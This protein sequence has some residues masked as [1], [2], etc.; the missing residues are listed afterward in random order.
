MNYDCFASD[1]SSSSS[2][3]WRQ[4]RPGIATLQSDFNSRRRPRRLLTE[5]PVQW[6][7]AVGTRIAHLMNLPSGWDGYGGRPLTRLNAYF[8]VKMLASVC[9]PK[10]ITPSLV[11]LPSGGVQIEWHHGTVDFEITIHSPSRIEVFLCDENTDKDGKEWSISSDFSS[12][13]P[14]MKKLSENA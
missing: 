3:T 4:L 5:E 7:E 11:P 2:A 6:E 14:P 1:E 8:T 9:G 12:L 10:T 13:L